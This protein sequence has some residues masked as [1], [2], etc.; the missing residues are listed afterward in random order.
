[1]ADITQPLA[2]EAAQFDL[3][4]CCL[5]ME[6]GWVPPTLNHDDRDDSDSLAAVHV[7][8]HDAATNT[9]R[10][11]SGGVQWLDAIPSVAG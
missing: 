1:M 3:V 4:L 2:F 6:H 9:N 10:F 5:A 7:S 8:G 11:W